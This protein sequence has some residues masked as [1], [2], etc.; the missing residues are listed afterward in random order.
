MDR[1]KEDP[2]NRKEEDSKKDEKYYELILQ[3]GFYIYFLMCYYMESE[4][5]VEN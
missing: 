5:N 3:K 2:E 1:I 4:R